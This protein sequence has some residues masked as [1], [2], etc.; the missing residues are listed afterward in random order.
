MSVSEQW[1]PHPG[2][3]R[4]QRWLQRE[5]P[6]SVLLYDSLNG[7]LQLKTLSGEKWVPAGWWITR[8]DDGAV[9]ISAEEPDA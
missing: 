7:V 6:G 8:H 5:I 1:D 2:N 9:T 3:A 4:M